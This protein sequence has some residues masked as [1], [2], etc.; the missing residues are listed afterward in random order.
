MA[1]QLC[2]GDFFKEKLGR[3]QFCMW[4]NF[5]LLCVSAGSWLLWCQ[6]APKRVESIALL[7]TFI[8]CAI[9]MCLHIGAYLY[10]RLQGIKNPTKYRAKEDKVRPK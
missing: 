3:C 10:Y 1:C 2:T 5:A 6:S 7:L 9:W 8:G 4:L